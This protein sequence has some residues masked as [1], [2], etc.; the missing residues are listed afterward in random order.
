[1]VEVVAVRRRVYPDYVYCH[2]E[3]RQ[4][5]TEL[6]VPGAIRRRNHHSGTTDDVQ[7]MFVVTELRELV[8]GR[9]STATT[10]PP[11]EGYE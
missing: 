1:M 2:H 4:G 10:L 6:V 9:L 11:A 7:R 5:S 3:A 8:T